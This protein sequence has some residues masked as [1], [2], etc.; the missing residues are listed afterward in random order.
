MLGKQEREQTSPKQIEVMLQE[1]KIVLS[2]VPTNRFSCH[3]FLPIP[4]NHLL[5]LYYSPSS[6]ASA[7]FVEPHLLVLENLPLQ[8]HSPSSVSAIV[9]SSS[10]AGGTVG[11]GGVGRTAPEEGIRKVLL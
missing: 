2:L 6:A 8:I 7:L 10:A 9:P 11:H 5:S 1:Q 3:F 4:D